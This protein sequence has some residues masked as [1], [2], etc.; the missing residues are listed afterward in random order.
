VLGAAP[1]HV[2]LYQYPPAIKEIIER[3][4]SVMLHFGLI[5]PSISP[6]SSLVLL[7]KEDNSWRFC[8]DFLQLNVITVKSVFPVPVMEE[9]L[10][11]LGQASWFCS[12][13]LTVV[14]NH[15]LLQP[16][17]THRT[18]FQTNM[19]HY[20]FRVMAFGL[21]GAH[22]TSYPLVSMYFGVL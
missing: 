22:A 18:T 17:E 8:V 1:V 20:E 7:V 16:A 19:S 9:L 3:Q 4:V 15:I 5:Q 21:T 2:R 6:F 13:D 12:L 10:D 11:E 14:Y